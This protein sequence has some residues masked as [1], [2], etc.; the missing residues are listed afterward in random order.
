[1]SSN[2]VLKLR[3]RGRVWEVRWVDRMTTRF[4]LDRY[5]GMCYFE[6]HVIELSTEMPDDLKTR[7]FLH[8]VTHAVLPNLPEKDVE[9]LDR[10]LTKALAAFGALKESHVA[11]K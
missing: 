11:N 1:M 6:E 5:W 10:D 8:E 4:D 3:I 2:E 9:R 7:I